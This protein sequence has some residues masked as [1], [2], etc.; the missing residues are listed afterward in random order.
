MV[1]K[2]VL[3][4]CFSQ[5]GQM[6]KIMDSIIAPL[7]LNNEVDITYEII[8]PVPPFPFPWNAEQFFQTFPESVKAIPC[9]LKPF[10]FSNDINFDLVIVAYQP[11]YLSPSI[12]FHAF[13]QSADAKE[14]IKDKP[15]ITVIGCRNMWVMAQEDVKKYIFEAGG[16]LVG[17][18]ALRDRAPNLLSVISIV[19]WLIKGKKEK[20]LR[21]IPEAGVS[22]KD[23]KEAEC[24]GKP[25]LNALLDNNYSGLQSDWIRLKA[26][27]L[28]PSLIMIEK[29]GKRLFGIWANW[30]LKKGNYGEKSRRF[31]LRV[32][33][34]YLF[35]V[36]YLISPIGTLVFYLTYPFRIIKIKKNKM[37]YSSCQLRT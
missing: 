31:R 10:K 21:I 20:Y 1:M 36:I 22:D 17:N 18:I 6:V 11:W 2:K 15:V 27:E 32:F 29:S 34:Y 19:R 28:I 3:I 7:R 33:M 13:F 9:K 37:Y 4:V 12:P 8:E 26:I 23:I 35:A 16:K 25:L 14:L 30:I 5:T 24:Y